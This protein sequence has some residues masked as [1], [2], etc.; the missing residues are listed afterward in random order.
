MSHV[1]LIFTLVRWRQP[2]NLTYLKS[3]F[4]FTT[5]R[6]LEYCALTCFFFW[7]SNIYSRWL[8]FARHVWLSA[9]I[10]HS[11]VK[12]IT[13]DHF[14]RKSLFFFRWKAQSFNLIKLQKINVSLY[15]LFPRRC[16]MQ[17][18]I[19]LRQIRGS[20]LTMLHSFNR[21]FFEKKQT[22]NILFKCL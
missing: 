22:T 20:F 4:F 14:S 13:S 3:S 21:S 5:A 11:L 10:S 1:S 12:A 15:F 8:G 7:Q 2:Q 6:E 16:K 17:G 19:I 18:N 9:A